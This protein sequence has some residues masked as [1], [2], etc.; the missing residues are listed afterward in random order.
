MAVNWLLGQPQDVAGQFQAGLDSG[1]QR[2][3]QD[4]VLQQRQQLL[5]QQQRSR[6]VAA[7]AGQH[8][9]SGDFSGAGAVAAKSGDLDLMRTIQ[10]LSQEQRQQAAARSQALGGLYV[11]ARQM[12]YEQRRQFIAS[13]RD[14]LINEIGIPPDQ[15]DSYDPTDQRLDAD[16]ATG[17]TMAQALEQN[18]IHWQTIPG[19]GA[20]ATDGRGMPTVPG[21]Q[22]QPAPQVP[23]AQPTAQPPAAGPTASADAFPASMASVFSQ[24]GVPAPVIA[25]ILANGHHESG[26]QWSATQPGDGGTAHGAF[27][28]R[29]ERAD[30][31]Q[32][33]TGAHPS[34]ATPEQTA[35]FVLW[36]LQNPEAAGMTREQA[37]AILN[38]QTPEDAALLFSQHYERPN[39]QFAHNDRR[40]ALASQYAGGQQFA[41]A[42]VPQPGQQRSIQD[43]AM[44]GTIQAPRQAPPGYQ[45]TP[46]GQ[47]APIQ[48]GPGDRTYDRSR[49]AQTDARSG[50]QEIGQVLGQFRGDPEVR[51]WRQARVSAQQLETL[52]RSG[53]AADDMAMIF[54]FMKVLDPNSTVR[55]SEFATA[56]NSAG[57]DDRVRNAYNQLLSGQRLS[58]NQRREMVATAGRLYT[59]RSRTYNELVQ[60][61]RDQAQAMGIPPAQIGRMFPLANAPR[62]ADARRQQ[63]SGPTIRVIARRP[64]R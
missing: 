45:W 23:Q 59:D 52:G 13:V 34:Q 16:I 6:Q 50:R 39:A 37:A 8:V 12:P 25:G 61:Y 49:D 27:Q 7:S 30:N 11:Q 56:Q 53:T 63:R 5:D 55:E 2:Q 20:F 40:A 58:P 14:R 4:A 48:G 36:E 3:Q 43:Q 15:I 29:N 46:Q 22:G 51:A 28:W 41:Q 54:S 17:M 19:V 26:G 47:L 42:A 32:R 21:Q 24:A 62:S 1:R 57:V 10:G 18:S 35:Q 33:I 31:F 38:A 44:T 60:S 64:A 9:A